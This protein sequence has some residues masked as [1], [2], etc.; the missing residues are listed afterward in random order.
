MAQKKITRKE[1]LKSPDE[2]LTFSEKVFTFIRGRSRQFITA[3]IVIVVLL[4]LVAGTKYYLGLTSGRA[5]AAYDQAVSGLESEKGFDPQRAKTAVRELE[6]VNSS[7]SRY[8]PGRHALLDLASLYYKL[9][10]LDK[11]QK[12]YQELLDSL[13]TE[14]KHLKPMLL[15]SLAYVFEDQGEYTQAE[16]KWNEVLGL[17]GRLMKEDAHLGLGRVFLAREMDEKAKQIYQRF[18]NDFPN[19]PSA[20]LVKTKLARLNKEKQPKTVE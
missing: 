13:R 16:A 7:Y 15:A 11:A 17:S 6:K 4:V 19:S 14:E 2:F 20:A 18:L 10:Q 8:D 12:A 9:G 5:L 1:L 3:G